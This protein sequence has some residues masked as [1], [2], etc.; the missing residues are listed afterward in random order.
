[1]SFL[2][3]SHSLSSWILIPALSTMEIQMELNLR[4]K[5]LRPKDVGSAC[6]DAVEE[7]GKRV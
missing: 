4:A 1:M 3:Q 5:G 2:P 7:E 6:M